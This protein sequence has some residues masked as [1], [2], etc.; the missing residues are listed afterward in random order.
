MYFSSYHYKKS[1]TFWICLLCFKKVM[2]TIYKMAKVKQWIYKY[3]LLKMNLRNKQLVI[4]LPILWHQDKSFRNWKPCICWQP[5]FLMERCITK[6]FTSWHYGNYF[7]WC[8]SLLEI[9][10]IRTVA[11]YL[12]FHDSIKSPALLELKFWRTHVE[13]WVFEFSEFVQVLSDESGIL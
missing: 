8:L 6:D 9:N 10:F 1:K 3:F 4:L 2:L 7:S 13:L 11:M 5:Y 12:V